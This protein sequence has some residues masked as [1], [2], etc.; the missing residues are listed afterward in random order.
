MRDREE[1]AE[2]ILLRSSALRRR[3][4]R[5]ADAGLAA[6]S[7]MLA[8]LL[9]GIFRL[10][11]DGGVSRATGFYGSAL[12]YSD[13]GGYVLAGVAAFVLGAA[14]TAVCIRYREKRKDDTKRKEEEK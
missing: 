7:G 4:K 8:A 9:I 13:A 6:A 14:V 12:L 11:G 3:R 2:L 5:R 1:R 10:L